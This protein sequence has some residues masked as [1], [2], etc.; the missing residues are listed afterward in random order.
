NHRGDLATARQA[1][2]GFDAIL[3]GGRSLMLLALEF[4]V[5]NLAVVTV[6]NEL[7]FEAGSAEHLCSELA[8][9]THAL[10][11]A[12]EHAAALVAKD[13][14]SGTVPRERSEEERKLWRHACGTGPAFAAPDLELGMAFGT[15]ARSH[16][17]LGQHDDALRAAMA[18]RAR[19]TNMAFEL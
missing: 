6:Q 2:A 11:E 3:R 10:V 14:A 5:R 18:A 8:A 19:F 7:P 9:R 17:F 12:A 15:I 16:A 4:Q 1:V 13:P